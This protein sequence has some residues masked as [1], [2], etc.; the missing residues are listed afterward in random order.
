MGEGTLKMFLVTVP[1]G[2]TSFTDVLHF[3]SWMVT[4]VSV[5]DTTFVCDA[6]S[7]LGGH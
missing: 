2:P 4:L 5:D 6:F 7:I 3:A 1:K